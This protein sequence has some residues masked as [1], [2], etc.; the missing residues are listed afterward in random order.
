MTGAI[1]LWCAAPLPAPAKAGGANRS[2]PV[3]NF[4]P[5]KQVNIKG[6]W[7]KSKNVVTVAIAR[8]MAAFPWAIAQQAPA[9]PS[10]TA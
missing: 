6:R 4:S 2:C 9:T 5:V 10:D 8:E 1:R 7:Y 3:G